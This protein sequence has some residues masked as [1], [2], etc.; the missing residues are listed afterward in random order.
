MVAS[1]DD[2]AVVVVVVVVY[3]TLRET[4]DFKGH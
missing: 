3:V 4:V 2:L 1:N